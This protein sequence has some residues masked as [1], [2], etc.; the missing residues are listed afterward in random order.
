MTDT[1]T[2]DRAVDDTGG[3]VLDVQFLYWEGCP[4]HERAMGLLKEVLEAE[5][6]SATLEALE[7]ETDEAAVALHFPGSP[8]IRINGADIDPA[9]DEQVIGLT[10][11]A[12]RDADGRVTPLPPRAL[13]ERAVRG[14]TR[15]VR[16]E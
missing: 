14:V 16:G 11:R 4:S 3:E 1:A 2:I 12:Y 10:C 13:I 9:I 6:V 5:G 8:T 15:P 7:V